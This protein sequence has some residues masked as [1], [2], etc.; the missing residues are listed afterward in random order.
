MRYDR[1]GPELQPGFAAFGQRI[2]AIA[3]N[4]D[5]TLTVDLDLIFDSLADEQSRLH[6]AAD[7][8]LT[9]MA[10]FALPTCA[11]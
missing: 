7:H 11:P 6:R 10:T 1:R 3:V 4:Q 2:V 5:N 9:R 8:P